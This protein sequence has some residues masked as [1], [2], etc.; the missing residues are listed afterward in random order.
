[1]KIHGIH[2]VE[3]IIETS[4]TQIEHIYFS[5]HKAN[6]G[7][8]YLLKQCKKMKIPYSLVP[9]SKIKSIA[10][11][12]SHQGI[13]AITSDITLL[14]EDEIY[15]NV[16]NGIFQRIFVPSNI[17]DP[18]NL[19]AIIRSAVAFNVDLILLEK[20]R[21]TPIS[22]TVYKTSAGMIEKI[23]VAKPDNLSKLL[24]T[25]KKLGF[26][27]VGADNNSEKLL[28][29]GSFSK[30]TVII[31]GNEHKGIPKYLKELCDC[32]YRIKMSKHAESLNVSVAAAII[33]YEINKG[34]IK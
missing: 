15:Y 8:F 7:L 31:T 20:K 10:K 32:M 14:E 12:D 30:R 17:Q 13:V 28:S 6:S 1:M 21:N 9:N 34:H 2:P 27:I 29:E 5:K 26:E 3:E 22:S 25:I 11:S 16:E 23:S 4:K 18:H 33:M 19:G 24:S